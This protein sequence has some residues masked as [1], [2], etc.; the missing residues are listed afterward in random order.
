MGS[1]LAF[2][3]LETELTAALWPAAEGDHHMGEYRWRSPPVN[4]SLLAGPSEA[5]EKGEG[6]K[7]KYNT[8]HGENIVIK[9]SKYWFYSLSNN[10]LGIYGI[11]LNF[12][13]SIFCV[14]V[15]CPPQT[16][17][18]SVEWRLLV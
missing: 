16:T 1:K 11:S 9:T 2:V 13:I 10:N 5:V 8:K 15:F 7:L 4:L 6:D 18:N 12:A 14:F 3:L 17:F